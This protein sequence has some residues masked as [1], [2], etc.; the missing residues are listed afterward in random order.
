MALEKNMI[1]SIDIILNSTTTNERKKLNLLE[2]IL[3]KLINTV[4]VSLLEANK[5][6]SNVSAQKKRLVLQCIDKI[7]KGVFAMSFEKN[8][9]QIS[10][11][12]CCILFLCP[13]N[14]YYYEIANHEVKMLYEDIL[15]F[16]LECHNV[17]NITQLLSTNSIK[18]ELFKIFKL[19]IQKDALENNYSYCLAFKRFLRHS[20]TQTFIDHLN[21]VITSSLI[22]IDDFNSEIILIGLKCIRTILQ[23]SPMQYLKPC[24]GDVIYDALQ[25]KMNVKI[26]SIIDYLYP[27]LKSILD[28]LEEKPFKAKGLRYPSLW[29]TVLSKLILNAFMETRIQEKIALAESIFLFLPSLGLTIARHS[30]CIFQLIS[31][32]LHIGNSKVIIIAMELLL[33]FNENASFCILNRKNVIFKEINTLLYNITVKTF[34]FE[35]NE[36]LEILEKLVH[37]LRLISEDLEFRQIVN[38]NINEDFSDVYLKCLNVSIE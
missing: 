31:E 22:L 9:E 14:P 16:L 19:K 20:P 26:I 11:I 38:L 23:K 30:D 4:K 18:M 7:V 13:F 1:C 36:K 3:E 17:S 5:D 27:S 35:E 33:I 37:V 28:I 34:S 12:T 32:F 24:Y 29:D 8:F 25:K 2:Q 15:T 21:E 6:A 10:K